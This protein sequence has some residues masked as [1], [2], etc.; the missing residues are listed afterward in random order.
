MLS[1]GRRIEPSARGRA[2]DALGRVV[3][4]DQS[5]IVA[6]AHR[7]EQPEQIGGE[8]GVEALQHGGLSMFSG[9]VNPAPGGRDRCAGH[10][11]P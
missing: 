6:M 7:G 11:R 10:C 5:E 9:A 3:G 8:D 2:R 4:V 1:P